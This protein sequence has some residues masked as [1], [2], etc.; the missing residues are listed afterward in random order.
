MTR[1]LATVLCLLFPLAAMAQNNNWPKAIAAV[2]RSVQAYQEYAEAKIGPQWLGAANVMLD[3]EKHKCAILG[4]M[5]GKIDEI[6]TIEQMDYPPMDSRSDPYDLLMFARSLDNWV[7]QAN[8][9][10]SV[11]T[12]ERANRWNLDCVGNFDIPA[13]AFAGSA[14]REASFEYK[15]QRLYVY[16]D[17]DAGFHERFKAELDRHGDVKEVYLGSGGGSV[18]DALLSGSEIRNRGLETSLHGNCWS[19]CPLVFAG[20]VKRIVWADV[21]H[22]FGFHQLATRDG[23]AL[24][25]DHP[26]YGMIADYL[27]QMGVNASTYLG[28]MQSASPSEMFTPKPVEWCKPVLVTFLQRICVDGKEF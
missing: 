10:I 19:A 15:F 18:K 5:L 24:P 1:V 25:L 7:G 16:G 17:I 27:T 12:A 22:D 26:I 13:D 11:D 3:A 4:R 8:W 28:W 21:R 14:R 6:R 23:Q 2:T 9:A 20:G